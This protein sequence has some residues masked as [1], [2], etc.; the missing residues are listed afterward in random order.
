MEEVTC[1]TRGCRAEAGGVWTTLTPLCFPG[2]RAPPWTFPLGS[3]LASPVSASAPPPPPS[4]SLEV[5]RS[6]SPCFW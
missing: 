3:V 6:L 1:W 2:G 5:I 4:N